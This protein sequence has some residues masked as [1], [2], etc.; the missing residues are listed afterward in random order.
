M[1]K[2]KMYLWK[3]Q[4]EGMDEMEILEAE[5]HWKDKISWYQQYD[6][7]TEVPEDQEEDY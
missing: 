7:M 6:S 3:Y 2:R 5:L 1:R 4:Q